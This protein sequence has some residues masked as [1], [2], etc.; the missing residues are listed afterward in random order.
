MGFKSH[1]VKRNYNIESKVF[2]L[3]SI[4][5]FVSK[6]VHEEESV[7]ITFGLN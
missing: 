5:A 6:A 7:K 4:S 3:I 1:R 2:N